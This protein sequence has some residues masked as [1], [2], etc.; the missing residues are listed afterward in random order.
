LN[1]APKPLARE[2]ELRFKAAQEQER[3][4]AHLEQEAET[5]ERER[6]EAEERWEWGLGVLGF[7][8]WHGLHVVCGRRDL[9][10]RRGAL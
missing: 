8:V 1:L 4:R 9:E 3:L 5:L 6:I 2:E 10:Q 7:R